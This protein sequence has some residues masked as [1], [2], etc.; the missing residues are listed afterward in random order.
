MFFK[1]QRVF[2]GLAI[3]GALCGGPVAAE[4]ASPAGAVV[5][6]INVKDGDTVTNS[7]KVQLK[8]HGN[9]GGASR[10]SNR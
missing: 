1:D 9:G 4:T 6:I 5:Y 2:L 8:S 3:A 10:R 7:F